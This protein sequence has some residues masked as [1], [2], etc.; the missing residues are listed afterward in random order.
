MLLK[1]TCPSCGRSDQ[2]SDRVI[3]KEVRCP[4]GATF[5]VVG[6]KQSNQSTASPPIPQPGPNPPQY[7]PAPRQ[8]QIRAEPTSS[9]RSSDVYAPASRPERSLPAAPT[10]QATEQRAAGGLPP[11][12]Y[13]AFG[14]AGVLFLVVVGAL[15]VSLSS[16]TAPNVSQTGSSR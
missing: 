15:I 3:G 8:T 7:V 1:L 2:A 9:S 16:S 10:P 6:P 14:G 13:A 12:V 5:R 11:W 4:C